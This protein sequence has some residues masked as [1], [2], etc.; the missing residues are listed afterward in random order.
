MSQVSY[1]TIGPL[2]T[3]LSLRPTLS[4]F[5]DIVCCCLEHHKKCI[6]ILLEFEI[7]IQENKIKLGAE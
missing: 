5:N 4:N 2:A 7:L 3:E 6:G 1:R